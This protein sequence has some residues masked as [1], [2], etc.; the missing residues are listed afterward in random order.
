MAAES[1]NAGRDSGA[2]GISVPVSSTRM[3]GGAQASG[4]LKASPASSP[5]TPL[6]TISS[7]MRRAIAAAVSPSPPCCVLAASG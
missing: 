2:T 3:G 5:S 7:W 1:L 4:S 6:S